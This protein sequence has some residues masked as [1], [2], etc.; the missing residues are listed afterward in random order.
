MPHHATRGAFRRAL[1]SAILL[2]AIFLLLPGGAARATAFCEVKAT[3]DGF[4][5]LRDAPSTGGKLIRRLK[6]GEMV[7][8]D[9]TRRN[10]RG[11]KAVIFREDGEGK[12]Q[13][14]WV[15]A[16]LIERECG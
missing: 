1:A 5:A 11:W 4:V 6:A 13:P 14:G 3:R 12:V 15:S 2:A 10:P 7:Q 16:G 8:L 9:S